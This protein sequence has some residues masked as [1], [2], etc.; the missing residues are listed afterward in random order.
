VFLWRL[1]WR[2]RVRQAL[3]LDSA[4]DSL[5]AS[6]DE[7]DSRSLAAL[8]RQ[9]LEQAMALLWAVGLMQLGSRLLVDG[10]VSAKWPATA[11]LGVI[12]GL[13]LI[14][15]FHLFRWV[16]LPFA[17]GLAGLLA[18]LERL[19]F[20][21]PWLGAAAVLY[22]LLVWRSSVAALA[23]PATWRLA[24]GVG[25]HRPRRRGRR[26]A[27]GGELA[28]LRP[29]GRGGTG[30]GQSG[31][32]AVGSAGI[33]RVA[34]DFPRFVAVRAGGLA[35]P[36]RAARLR[37]ADRVDGRGLAGRGGVGVVRACLAWGNRCST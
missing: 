16:A 34:G 26:P 33:G 9:P 7:S 13:L 18:G 8:I 2:D 29:A 28:R 21:L 25:L 22:A 30:R 5:S 27:G 3:L 1:N 23:Q 24:A 37:G 12:S 35:L 14:G 17:L 20:P 15:Y 11:G 19:G 36:I 31:A 32:G 4:D 6:E 10:D